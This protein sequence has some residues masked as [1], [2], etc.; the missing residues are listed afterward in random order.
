MVIQT[1]RP[2]YE[3]CGVLRITGDYI[4]VNYKDIGQK[5]YFE[6]TGKD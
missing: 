2:M 3:R 1:P 6:E 5:D 4:T